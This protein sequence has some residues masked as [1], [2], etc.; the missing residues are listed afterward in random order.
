MYAFNK[1]L[2]IDRDTFSRNPGVR[3]M[4][5]KYENNWWIYSENMTEEEKAAHPEHET[6]GGYIKSVDFK[7]ACKMMWDNMT[8]H[9]KQAV[10][11]IPNFDAGIFKKITGI[12]VEE[13]HAE[14][15]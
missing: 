15:T 8:D 11:E 7:T 2:R 9:E 1:I 10:R 6:T 14:E 3:A 13:S 4:N 12:E 5:W